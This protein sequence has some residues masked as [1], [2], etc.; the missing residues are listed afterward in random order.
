MTFVDP[1]ATKP[2][3]SGGRLWVC[4]GCGGLRGGNVFPVQ[5]QRMA[6]LKLTVQD[7]WSKNMNEHDI[8]ISFGMNIFPV[9]ITFHNTPFHTFSLFSFLFPF[10]VW[11]KQVSEMHRRLHAFSAR[12]K[13]LNGD[14]L[15]YGSLILC[16]AFWLGGGLF[17]EKKPMQIGFA[18]MLQDN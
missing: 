11:N 6:C 7:T 18:T 12:C 3:A 15:L 9:T 16:R 17:V 8:F 13:C 10:F 5:K 2:D 14:S 1:Q 4:P